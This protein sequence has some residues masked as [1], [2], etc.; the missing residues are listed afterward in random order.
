MTVTIK[1][2]DENVKATEETETRESLKDAVLAACEKFGADVVRMAAREGLEGY[3]R[4]LGRVGL[5]GQYDYSQLLNISDWAF[6]LMTDKEKHIES[7]R[8]NNQEPWL[9]Q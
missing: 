3:K 9:F 8:D 2:K 1:L 7:C 5:E 6:S 4:S